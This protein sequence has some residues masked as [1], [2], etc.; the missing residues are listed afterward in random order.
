LKKGQRKK[1]DMKGAGSA[2][3]KRDERKSIHSHLKVG[4]MLKESR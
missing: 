2:N 4:A 3:W 1:V